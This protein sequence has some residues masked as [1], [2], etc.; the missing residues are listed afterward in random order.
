M[1]L[2][3]TC[4]EPIEWARTETGARIPLNLTASPDAANIVLEAGVARV[5]AAGAGTH[6]AHFATCPQAADHRRRSR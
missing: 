5:V 4:H 1:S 3:R 2:C 6:I